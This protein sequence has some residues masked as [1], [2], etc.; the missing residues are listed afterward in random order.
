MSSI[1]S[2]SHFPTEISSLSRL[3]E[4]AVAFN[5]IEDIGPVWSMQ[6]MEMLDV[7]E[8][9][10]TDRF[11]KLPSLEYLE[12]E[13]NHFAHLPDLR[14]LYKLKGLVLSRMKLRSVPAQICELE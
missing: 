6:T 14:R 2:P 10:I 4:V 11:D 7:R 5:S 1:Q 9:K 12:L 8:R 13:G 3:K